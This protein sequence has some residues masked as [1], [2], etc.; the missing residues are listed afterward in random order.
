MF[1]AELFDSEEELVSGESNF[2]EIK[3]YENPNEEAK[4]LEEEEKK[5]AGLEEAKGKNQKSNEKDGEKKNEAG[6]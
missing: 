1:D 3:C 2:H 6:K 4:N 5:G